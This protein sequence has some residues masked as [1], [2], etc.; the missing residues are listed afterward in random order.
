[1][2]T[3]RKNALNYAQTVELPILKA[4][5]PLHSVPIAFD[6]QKDEAWVVGPQVFGFLKGVTAQRREMATLSTLFA[7]LIA[8]TKFPRKSTDAWFSAYATAL[9]NVGWTITESTH[10]K[11]EQSDIGTTVHEAIIEFLGVAA[12]GATAVALVAAALKSLQKVGENKPWITLFERQTRQEEIT[13]FQVGL[14]DTSDDGVFQVKLMH[15][16]LRLGQ[17]NT[18]IL[19]ATFSTLGVSMDAVANTA[20]VAEPVLLE[21]LPTIRNRL[22]SYV[23]S[24]V[25]EVE[26]PAL[27]T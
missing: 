21:T 16:S 22:A 23:K 24:Y 6:P 19:F 12:L 15:F 3:S 8:D 20:T 18:Q 2:E 13:G 5:E 4:L 27:S 25:G 10:K 26:L 7:S 17:S 9:T 11:Y 1:M 14:V